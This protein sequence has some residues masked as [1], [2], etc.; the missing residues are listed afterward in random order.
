[1]PTY[2]N[3]LRNYRFKRRL[4]QQ[5]VLKRLGHASPSRLSAWENGSAQPTMMH[6]IELAKLYGVSIERLMGRKSPRM[7][8]QKKV[9][10]KSVP[11]TQVQQSEIEPSIEKS[12]E[13]LAQILVEAYLVAAK[14]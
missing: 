5:Q 6:L 2:T 10:T 7:A 14:R 13:Q 4:T 8:H 1:M 12:I 9:V 3:N 11:T